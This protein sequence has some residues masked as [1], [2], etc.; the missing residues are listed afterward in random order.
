M[1]R[2]LLP[3][4]V[5]NVGFYQIVFED[6]SRQR[7]FYSPFSVGNSNKRLLCVCVCVCVQGREG[8]HC[9]IATKQ[10]M[11]GGQ[12]FFSYLR[13]TPK[14]LE[15]KINN[16]FEVYQA[17]HRLLHRV[18][19]YLAFESCKMCQGCCWKTSL[20]PLHTRIQPFG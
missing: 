14:S 18:I 15:H 8:I 6:S 17:A 16:D 2:M 3:Q 19:Q 7:T 9:F 12:A 11:L 5:G 20:W 4:P 1:Y 10:R 13:K